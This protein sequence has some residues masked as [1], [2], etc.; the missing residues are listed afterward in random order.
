METC[1]DNSLST[2]VQHHDVIKSLTTE[3]VTY[4][5]IQG[6]RMSWLRAQ[7]RL[8]SETS[9]GRPITASDDKHLKQGAAVNSS[10]YT[11]ILKHIRHPF[12]HVRGTLDSVI[13]QNDNGRSHTSPVSEQAMRRLNIE[14]IPHPQYAPDLVRSDFYF[15]IYSRTTSRCAVILD[16]P[17]I[18]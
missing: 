9:S 10:Q 18:K 14:P 4:T 1:S 2:R 13:L 17:R 16:Y 11:E 12:C 3:K 6:N 8:K 7:K 15:F 5:E